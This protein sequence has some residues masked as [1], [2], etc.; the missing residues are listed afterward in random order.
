MLQGI[1]CFFQNVFS[2][3]SNLE[4]L[5]GECISKDHKA[6]SN[7]LLFSRFSYIWLFATRWTATCQTSLSFT[8]FWNL[9]NPMSIVSVMPSN[10]HILCPLQ[11]PPPLPVHEGGL[12]THF[13]VRGL[14]TY[15]F[16]FFLLLGLS[17]IRS[18]GE[19][20]IAWCPVF[21]PH[22]AQGSCI[23]E[24]SEEKAS[25]TIFL[26]TMLDVWVKD[27]PLLSFGVFFFFSFLQ[28]IFGGYFFHSLSL[29]SL[30]FFNNLEMRLSDS[31]WLSQK[32]FLQRGGLLFFSC[33]KQFKATAFRFLD[34]F[35]LYWKLKLGK[36]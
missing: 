19:P 4:D 22:Y 16:F 32:E 29:F 13:E 9:L 7:L 24:P 33:W 3:T 2:L 30:F 31:P 28:Y 36:F 10:H 35:F 14:A 23:L 34:V 27:Y 11:L 25:P 12:K 1:N 8:I 20:I 15:S 18:R 5:R 26:S 6:I 17:C 21:Q